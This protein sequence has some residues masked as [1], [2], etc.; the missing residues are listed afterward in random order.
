[1]VATNTSITAGGALFTASAAWFILRLHRSDAYEDTDATVSPGLTGR[2]SLRGTSCLSAPLPY[3]DVFLR[4]LGDQCDPE[5][6]STGHI[7]MCMAE[8]K[9]CIDSLSRRL[10]KPGTATSA[11]SDSAVYGYNGFLGLPAARAS[12]AHFLT[13]HFLR[14]DNDEPG[15]SVGVSRPVGATASSSVGGRTGGQSTAVVSPQHVSFGSGC[16][17]LLNYLAYCLAE[18]GDAVLIPA[19]YYA[20]FESDLKLSGNKQELNGPGLGWCGSCAWR[21]SEV[22]AR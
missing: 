17:A 13:R 2:V 5:T 8:N 7:I 16:A 21:L 6:N 9:L 4:A 14:P 11:F 19:P 12:V 18:E 22:F 3:L 20:A 1:M 15:V 10:Q